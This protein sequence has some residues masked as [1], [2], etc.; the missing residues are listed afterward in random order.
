MAQPE[1]ASYSYLPTTMPQTRRLAQLYGH[2]RLWKGPCVHAIARSEPF[3]LDRLRETLRL[4]TCRHRALRTFY[5]PDGFTESAAC[6][7]PA[8]AAWPLTVRIAAAVDDE[9]AAMFAWLQRHF[10]PFQRPLVRAMV[11]R[12][13]GRDLLG[14]SIDHSV[15]DGLS[16]HVLL[17]DLVEVYHR[18]QSEPATALADVQTDPAAFAIAERRWLAAPGGRA[19]QAYWDRLHGELGPYPVLHLDTDLAGVGTSLPSV[20]HSVALS[21]ADTE[22]IA[23]QCQVL[24]LSEFMLVAAAS[25][26]SLREFSNEDR[27]AFMFMYARRI[28][29]TS[30]NL[31]GYVSN[32]AM[33]ALRVDRHDELAGISDQ[34]RTASLQSIKHGMLSHDHYLRMRHPELYRIT[35]VMPHLQINV[36]RQWPVPD[37]EGAATE[38]VAARQSTDVVNPPGLQVHLGLFADNTASLTCEYPLGM[39]DDELIR[40]LTLAI[41]RRCVNGV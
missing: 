39:Y 12:S 37:I 27:I 34:V 11:L 36:V 23:K 4:L 30:R 5:L 8:E 32:R 33:I 41:A 35:P 31:V 25:S 19:A 40:D 2:D 17:S 22:A 13:P 20:Y 7:P 1:A 16:A 15:F 38:R 29:S 10:D 6:L 14:L 24:R 26:L 18:L 28:W 21:H 3:E 9:E